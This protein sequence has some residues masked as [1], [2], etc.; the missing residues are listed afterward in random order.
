MPSFILYNLEFN[1]EYKKRIF[2]K[3]NEQINSNVLIN[4]YNQLSTE[5]DS[6]MMFGITA[7]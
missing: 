6:S 3:A 7:K 4:I 2:N 1:N 5:L